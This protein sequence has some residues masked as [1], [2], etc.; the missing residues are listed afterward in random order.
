MFGFLKKEASEDQLQNLFIN[1][2][3]LQ[4]WTTDIKKRDLSREDL[5]YILKKMSDKWCPN[6]TRDQISVVALMALSNNI[7]SFREIREKSNFD[8]NVVS[9]CQNLG[10]EEKYFC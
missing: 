2:S 4:S 10:L 6:A 1:I 7:D 8:N 5:Q 3:L 9:F